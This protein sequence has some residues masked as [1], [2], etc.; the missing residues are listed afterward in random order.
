MAKKKTTQISV[1]QEDSKQA[2]QMLEQYH[3]IANNLH[4]S[5]DQK[6][7]QTA[8]TEI[9]NMSEGAQIA[10]I[11][12]LSKETNTD[13]ADVLAAI[14]EL[15]PTKNV[16]KEA[17][18]S[19]IRLE[20]TRIYPSWTPPI[21]QV[22]TVQFQAPTGPLRFWKGIVTD[23]R[24]AGEVQLLLCFEREED[25][26][27]IRVLGFLLEFGFEG[28]KD[29]F[30]RIES[31]RRFEKF[32]DEMTAQ[33]GE[34]ETKDC[35]LAHGR[36][37]ILEALEVN[38]RGGAQPHRDY[39][40]NASL[41]NQLVLEAPDL[42][43]D[44]EL[45][46]DD[47]DEDEDE[48]IIDL[49]DLTPQDVVITFV[50]SWIDEDYDTAYELLSSDSPLHAGLSMDEWIERREDWAEEAVPAELQPNFIFEREAP[51]SRLWLPNPFSAGRSATRKEFEVGWSIEID[52]TPLDDTIPELPKATMVYE[53]TG[54]HWFWTS[55]V[56][57]KEQDAWRIQSMTDEGVRAQEL[58]IEELQ[59]RKQDLDKFLDDFTQK[60][61]LE[62]IQN[63][64][65][66][67][68][69]E[70]LG[71]VLRTVTRTVYYTDVLIKKLPLDNTLYEDAAGRTLM[72]RQLERSAAYLEQ[73]TQRFTEN[74]ALNLRELAEVQR[75][76]SNRFF[77]EDD[78]ERGDRFL[79]LAEQ[80]LRESLTLEDVFETHISLAEIL[81]DSGKFD[82]AEEHLLQAKEQATEPADLAHI[83]L[84]LGEIAM[85]R[86]EYREALSHYQYVTD[87]SPNDAVAWADVGEAHLKLGNFEEAETSYRRAIAL[88]PDEADYYLDLNN[89]YKERGQPEKGIEA[90]EEGLR[91]NPDSITLNIFLA[92]TYIERGDFDQAEEYVQEAERIDPEAEVVLMARQVLNITKATQAMNRS[93][94]LKSVPNV[95]K[96][97]RPVKKKKG[98]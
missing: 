59:K 11:K 24:D 3:Q 30:T 71:Q 94:R 95:G 84:H 29:F 64:T 17:K 90:I 73:L 54:R 25:P 46:E 34:I 41:V 97:G 86:E 52:D 91:N 85:E 10:L 69:L 87:Y 12:A 78:D 75:E 35:S 96:L 82:D 40:L 5:K 76:L 37:L 27:E 62:E 79:E 88:R 43:E 51:Q 42:E 9:N 36:R 72:F 13:A 16:R 20:E 67:A 74:R 93:N 48:D 39:R 23:T 49:H 60:H 55:Y 66:E 53:E 8:L 7:A 80:A 18:R 45:D 65:D 21:D 89:L 98:R 22:P 32:L 77:E 15:S 83:E 28:V 31:K 26:R 58:S 70:Y 50:E 68:A 61:K 4:E 57:V 19:L 33:M 81:I 6:Q 47:Y 56:L 14:D 1:S 92:T 2:Q 38:K 63:L 44:D